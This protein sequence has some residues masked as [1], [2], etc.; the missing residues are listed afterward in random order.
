MELIKED[1]A[2]I[3]E[4]CIATGY[5]VITW[6]IAEKRSIINQLKARKYDSTN[7]VFTLREVVEGHAL[8]AVKPAYIL[9]SN[10]NEMLPDM[11]KY[12]TGYEADTITYESE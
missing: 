2:Y 8:D 10:V 1:G 6:T 9:I 12:A 7:K 5:P 3:L 4:R 11:V